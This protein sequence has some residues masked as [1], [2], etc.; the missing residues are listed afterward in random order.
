MRTNFVEDLPRKSVSQSEVAIWLRLNV[1]WCSS[2]ACKYKKRNPGQVTFLKNTVGNHCQSRLNRIL[3]ITYP[4][5]QHRILTITYPHSHHHLPA[6]SPS[7]SH[8]HLPTFSPSH[9][10]HRILTITYPHS[11]HHLPAF[12]PSPTHPGLSGR[13][14]SRSA[15]TTIQKLYS[16]LS[17]P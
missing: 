10:H 3:T 9:S 11:H 1:W 13:F 8:H 17:G 5:S 15:F 16:K 14:R 2:E 4:H 7:Y 6:F 12:S